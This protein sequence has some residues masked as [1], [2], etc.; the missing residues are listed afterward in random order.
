MAEVAHRVLWQRH[1]CRGHGIFTEV[2]R[3]SEMGPNSIV[4]AT[5]T[6]MTADNRVPHH[7]SARMQ[8]LNVTPE[9][10]RVLVRVNVEWGSPLALR[11]SLMWTS[12]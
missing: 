8:I 10:N 2:I 11:I 3:T 6:E 9:L 5:I 4:M 1:L 12:P 7:G